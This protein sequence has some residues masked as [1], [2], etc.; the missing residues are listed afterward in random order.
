MEHH[1]E[2]DQH[3]ATIRVVLGD[4]LLQATDRI[5]RRLKVNRSALI[6]DA[7]REHLKRL[8]V[9]ERERLDREGYLRQPIAKGEFGVWDKVTAW[10]DNQS[11]ARCAIPPV[12]GRA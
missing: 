5:A 10:P 12:S 11:E 8:A 7:L 2:Y 1:V 3:M 4:S 9:T 6:R